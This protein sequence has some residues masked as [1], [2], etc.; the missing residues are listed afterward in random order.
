VFEEAMSGRHGQPFIYGLGWEKAG[1]KR[2]LVAAAAAAATA[3]M[4][5]TTT[6][7]QGGDAL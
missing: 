6:A 7:S 3:T 5:T 1:L 4:T 2:A